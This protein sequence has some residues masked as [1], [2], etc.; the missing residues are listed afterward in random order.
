MK[1]RKK[2]IVVEAIQFTDTPESRAELAK[3]AGHWV[4]VAVP[5]RCWVTTPS[6]AVL[7]TVGDWVIRGGPADY[8]PCK[9]DVFAATYEAV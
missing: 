5:G 9:P 6:G 8:Y 7:L 4:S 1:F 3:W 2:P